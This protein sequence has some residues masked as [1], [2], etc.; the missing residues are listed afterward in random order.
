[1]A[2]KLNVNLK[3]FGFS[4]ATIKRIQ[5]NDYMVKQINQFLAGGGKF[6]FSTE[7]GA[8]YRSDTNEIHFENSGL[9]SIYNV[10]AHELGHAL[11]KQQV[12]DT[13][14]FKGAKAYALA[15]GIGEAEAI[16]NEYYTIQKEII[17]NKLAVVQKNYKDY[18][19]M[20]KG[21]DNTQTNGE[22]KL[23][24]YQYLT[25]HFA[26]ASRQEIYNFLSKHNMYGMKPSGNHSNL[27]YYETDIGL[28]LAL[29]TEKN[30]QGI[31]VYKSTF[32]DD[33]NQAFGTQYT[34][35]DFYYLTRGGISDQDYIDFL[36][37]VADY[38]LLG[39]SGNNTVKATGAKNRMNELFPNKDTL[40]G[41]AY[42]YGDGGNDVLEGRDDKLSSDKILGGNGNDT[43]RGFSGD[44]LLAGNGDSDRMEGG[45]GFD[46]YIADSLDTISDSDG[47]GEVLFGENRLKLGQATQ[48]KPNGNIYTS[49]DGKIKYNFDANTKKLTVSETNSNNVNQGLVI[50]NF[51]SG[52]L[53]ITLLNTASG[54]RSAT[55]TADNL[56]A[57]AAAVTNNLINAMAAF[58]SD[59]SVASFANHD[60][61]TANMP[62]LAVAA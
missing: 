8:S 20:T 17:Q 15:R 48:D 40:T 36:K 59:N 3:N 12:T 54:T 29:A 49:L 21:Y 1:M 34:R 16:Y 58:G 27:T 56:V 28:Y 47:K 60:P 44:D 6:V 41:N 14:P 9:Y 46:S 23:N 5:S 19:T 35:D 57:H 30:S 18:Q 38:D 4:D 50:E 53:G 22:G 2:I 55:S 61:Y 7:G 52:S 62:Q 13:A 10:L 26:K 24:L 51:S 33:Y 32:A 37:G 39:D 45:L 43:L 11:G 31:E 42:M 25:K